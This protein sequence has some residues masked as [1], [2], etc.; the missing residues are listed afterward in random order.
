MSLAKSI[1]SY[2]IKPA[3]Q[4]S[5]L[6]S[7]A[8]EILVYGTGMVESEY[9]YIC[10]IGYPADGGLGY[11]QMEPSDF[12]DLCKWLN[13]FPQQQVKNNIL[14]CCYYTSMPIDPAVLMSNIKLAALLCRA[15]YLRIP[16]RLPSANDAHGMAVYHK[17]YYN[18]ML[19]DADVGKN[20]E[21][22]QE[23]IDGKL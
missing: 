11:F 5:N 8:A 12:K 2:I 15:H 19:G 18:S 13:A 3:L 1:R 17:K 22:F 9:Q 21:V 6:H 4:V 10:Q 7:Q 20:T 14:S 16:E 23:V